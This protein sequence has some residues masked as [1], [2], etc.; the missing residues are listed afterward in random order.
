MPSSTVRSFADPD[1]YA[2]SIRAT[3]YEVTVTG[4]GPF[5]ANLTRIDLN[6]MWMQRF[7]SNISWIAHANNMPGRAIFAFS[8]D[9]KLVFHRGVDEVRATEI[10]RLADGQA[11]YQR[12]TGPV[13]FAT[14]SLP[15]AVSATA[16]ATMAGVDLTP[17][18]H[19]VTLRPHPARMG[20][21]QR[22]HAAATGLAHDAPTIIANPSAALGLEQELLQALANG[23]TDPT[24]ES[25]SA[26]KRKHELI[27]RRFHMAISERGSEPVYL[28]E[29]CLALGVSGRT[30]RAC[31][32]EYL[33]TG[34][35]RY[36]W[37]RRMQLARRALEFAHPKSMS[38][39][40]IATQHGFWELGR[41]AVSYRALY[42][43]TPSATLA[44]QP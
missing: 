18:A 3:Q 12:A 5:S 15:I 29:V 33:G 43:E 7:E 20:E 9:P 40:A 22:L 10:I 25:D 28:S 41:F 14:M 17:P 6:T 11:T 16:G 35:L 36:L 34:P 13:S 38:V 23:L 1:D 8:T 19:A 44:R 24:L 26:A 30:L 37:L 21:L 32:Q 27:M 2:S 39:T 31:C 42:G 4:R